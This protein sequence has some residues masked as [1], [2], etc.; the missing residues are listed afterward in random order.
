MQLFFKFHFLHKIF[1]G[2]FTYMLLLLWSHTTCIIYKWQAILWFIIWC[3]IYVVIYVPPGS[4]EDSQVLTGYY[5][6]AFHVFSLC[7]IPYWLFL[8]QIDCAFQ[9]QHSCSRPSKRLL[10]SLLSELWFYSGFHSSSMRQKHRASTSIPRGESWWVQTNHRETH[11]EEGKRHPAL[12]QEW[13]WDKVLT[14]E[15]WT[16]ISQEILVKFSTFLRRTYEKKKSFF[17]FGTLSKLNDIPGATDTLWNHE[18][19]QPYDEADAKDGR[20]M[21]NSGSV[22]TQRCLSATKSAVRSSFLLWTSSMK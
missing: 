17:S 15:G 5:H 20:E 2:Q 21:K 14:D 6:L 12:A 7:T 11:G 1:S 18:W 9:T 22:Q 16:R 8:H 10:L 19:K 4:K 13:A 3:C